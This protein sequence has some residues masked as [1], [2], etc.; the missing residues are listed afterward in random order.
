MNCL[1]LLRDIGPLLGHDV[2]FGAPRR[3]DTFGGD[4]GMVQG[5]ILSTVELDRIRWL[6]KM[7]LVETARSIS[8]QAAAL[9]AET[10]LDQYHRVAER[11]GHAKLLSKSGRILSAEAVDEIRRMSLF[12]YLLEA[13]GPFYLSDEENVGH[14]QICFRIVRP[15]RREDIGSLHRDAWFWNYHGF[16]V[17]ADVGRVKVWVPVCSGLD[18]AGLLL[19]PGSHR[20]HTAYRTETIGGR[21]AFLPQTDDL[22]ADLR[23]YAGRPGEPVM[24][25]YQTLHVGAMTRGEASRVS[26]EFTIM[27][28][29]EH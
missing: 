26:F 3:E 21:L 19:A 28:R 17:P 18:Q 9:I 12:G 23:W 5:P 20:G 4:K 10:P 22:S 8:A 25:N 1:P 16:P 13:F 14:E 7:H 24:F 2:F 11:C 6:I 29:T 27:F 15:N